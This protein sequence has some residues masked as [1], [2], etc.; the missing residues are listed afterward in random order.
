M[1]SITINNP[2]K[3]RTEERR[4]GFSGYSYYSP[5]EKFYAAH[6][7]FEALVVAQ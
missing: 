2:R 6:I 7:T 1:A 3:E 4:R 5:E